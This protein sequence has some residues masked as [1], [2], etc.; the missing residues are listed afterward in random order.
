[1]LFSAISFAFALFASG[2]DGLTTPLSQQLAA[3]AEAASMTIKLT[4]VTLGQGVIVGEGG[5][6]ITTGDVAFGPDGNP[7]N[8]MDAIFSSGFST[9]ISV[10]GY[11][12]VTD[13]AMLRLSR[14][15]PNTRSVKLAQSNKKGVVLIVLPTGSARAEIS[16]AN[17]TGVMSYSQRY[18]PLTEIRL[19]RGGVPLAGAPLFDSSGNL[20][21]MLLASLGAIPPQGGVGGAGMAKS[22]VGASLMERAADTAQGPRQAATTF[23]LA[24]PVLNRVVNGFTKN[25]GVVLHPYVGVFFETNKSSETVI[26]RV[27]EGGPCAMAGIRAGDVVLTAGSSVI[28]NG[29]EFAAYLF[30]RQV[31]EIISLQLRRGNAL[32][33]AQ[34]AVV[35][36]PSPLQQK[37]ALRRAPSGQQSLPESNIERIPIGF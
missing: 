31:G 20:A 23:S 28:D 7:R 10:E 26:T 11:D 2:Q 21:G 36:D 25:N 14:T 29:F 32:I 34:V 18:V 22:A 24:M 19:E 5:V 9:K 1:M 12:P 16:N 8:G 3:S 37:S 35:A 30:E 6:A 27:V 17:V 4:N 13:I 15:P 33:N